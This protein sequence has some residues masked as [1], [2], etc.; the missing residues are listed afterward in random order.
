MND[1][2]DWVFTEKAVDRG[3]QR[4]SCGLCGRRNL[5]FQFQVRHCATGQTKWVGSRCILKFGMSVMQG[6]AVLPPDQARARLAR[7]MRALRG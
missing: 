2:G 6:Q 5:R 1:Y 3:H 7:I 4:G